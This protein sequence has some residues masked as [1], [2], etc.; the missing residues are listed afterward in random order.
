MNIVVDIEAVGRGHESVFAVAFCVTYKGKVETKVFYMTPVNWS[1]SAMNWWNSDEKRKRF[2]TNALDIADKM[3]KPKVIHDIREYIDMLYN[4]VQPGDQVVF[5]SDFP[6]FDIGLTSA[7][8]SEHGKLPLYL[9]DDASPPAMCVNYNTL[10]R[11]MTRTK[12][13]AKTAD[14]YAAL[15][16]QRPRRD[17]SHDPEYDVRVIMREVVMVVGGLL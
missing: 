16:L 9:K 2:L 14:A 8:L 10:L 3:D 11:G 7:L 6:E 12:L 13:S 4:R 17:D 5:F 15:D 1:P